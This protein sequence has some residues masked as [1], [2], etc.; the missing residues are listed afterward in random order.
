[1]TNCHF[2]STIWVTQ[3][4]HLFCSL[5]NIPN[6]CKLTALKKPGIHCSS[7]I[8]ISE[9][10]LIWKRKMCRHQLQNSNRILPLAVS[11]I[12]SNIIKTIS[13]V[14]YHYEAEVLSTSTNF[15]INGTHS[16]TVV[17]K[18]PLQCEPSSASWIK[19]TFLYPIAQRSVL[20]LL[21][22]VPQGSCQQFSFHVGIL[23][24]PF[25]SQE[26]DCN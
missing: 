15:F 24:T 13:M 11:V 17:F 8:V 1:M 9:I 2:M 26:L 18:K 22:S 25:I 21:S 23:H 7:N 19:F 16:F 14:Q 6:S 3:A 20:I 10:F 5:I 12:N 4:F